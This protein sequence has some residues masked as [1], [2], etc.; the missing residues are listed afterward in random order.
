MS[1]TAISD[2]SCLNKE[3]LLMQRGQNCRDV[4]NHLF[5]LGIYEQIDFN[6]KIHTFARDVANFL[7]QKGFSVLCTSRW[8]LEVI[9]RS[10]QFYRTAYQQHRQRVLVEHHAEGDCSPE[11]EAQA[12]QMFKQHDTRQYLV[13]MHHVY[14]TAG[15]TAA[16][17]VVRRARH[18][19]SAD[20][21][22]GW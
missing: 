17:A 10:M 5:A 8:A 2:H 11:L 7:D 19:A 13:R 14:R 4:T 22:S 21:S 15:G 6:I 20:L 18:C 12:H 3:L 9:W 16:S 1:F